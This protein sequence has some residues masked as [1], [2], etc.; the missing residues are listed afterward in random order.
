MDLN[1]AGIV[2]CKF[3]SLFF[4]G[5]RLEVSKKDE[6]KNNLEIANSISWGFGQASR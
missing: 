5:T 2:I 3:S 1:I 4:V 6:H